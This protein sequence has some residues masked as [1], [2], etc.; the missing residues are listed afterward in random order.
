MRDGAVAA[1]DMPIDLTGHEH[2]DITPLLL[3]QW[4]Y[5][6]TLELGPAGTYY[7]SIRPAVATSRK[8]HRSPIAASA[9]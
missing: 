4:S 1:G 7:A 5:G 8:A 2:T 6:E 3:Q 9:V